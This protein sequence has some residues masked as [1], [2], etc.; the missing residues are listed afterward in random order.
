MTNNVVHPH[1]H[2]DHYSL[3]SEVTFQPSYWH[4]SVKV[5]TKFSSDNEEYNTYD[6]KWGSSMKKFEG[7]S[8]DTFSHQSND[9]NILF[10]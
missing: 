8:G 1:R 9:L 3:H 4:F 2:I 10:E 5:T 7:L 6:N